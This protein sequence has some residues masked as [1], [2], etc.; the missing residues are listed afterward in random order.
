MCVCVHSIHSI[1]FNLVLKTTMNICNIIINNNN[2]NYN[3]ENLQ[4]S[5][6]FGSFK[7]SLSHTHILK[8]SIHCFSWIL[9]Y[10]YLI[11]NLYNL[12]LFHYL[13]FPKHSFCFLT[14]LFYSISLPNHNNNNNNNNNNN[15]PIYIYIYIYIYRKK[16]APHR[17]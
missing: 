16:Q 2:I 11:Y 8:R 12:C 10:L 14:V 5:L 17:K 9:I 6:T 7:L 1:H 13:P 15:I 4:M 3:S